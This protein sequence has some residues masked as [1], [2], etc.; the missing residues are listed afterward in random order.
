MSNLM[1]GIV[2]CFVLSFG[3]IASLMG[4]YMSNLVYENNLK[5]IPQ[6]NPN[7]LR[8]LPQISG[9]NNLGDPASYSIFSQ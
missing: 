5:L 9:A 1:F 4:S 6:A 7:C 8:L 2:T 3:L